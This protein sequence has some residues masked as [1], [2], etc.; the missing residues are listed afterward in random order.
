MSS[1]ETKR[2]SHSWYQRGRFFRAWMRDPLSVGALVPSSRSLA[3]LMVRGLKPGMRVIE[4]GAG[5]GM[6]TQAILDAGIHS[7]DL[8]VIE[9]NEGFAELL[10]LCFP[11]VAVVNA[12]ASSLDQHT[13]HFSGP[14]DAIISGLPLVL[15]SPEERARL[16]SMAMA[17]LSSNGSFYQ[18]SYVGRFPVGR[19]RR[20]SLE[21]DASLMGVALF[22]VPPAFVYRLRR[23]RQR[24]PTRRSLLRAQF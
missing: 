22:N 2:R 18:F 4:L 7:R 16:L 12:N 23:S 13:G 19:E 11:G 10:E 8:L 1:G 6:V 15:F 17:N 3:K 21:V 5:T 14:A 24:V 9:K 20:R